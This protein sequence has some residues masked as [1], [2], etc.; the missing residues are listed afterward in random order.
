MGQRI[1]Q[2]NQTNQT[3]QME[4]RGVYALPWRLG[5]APPG[6]CSDVPMSRLRWWRQCSRAAGSVPP[7]AL[8][9]VF[10]SPRHLERAGEPKTPQEFSQ[11]E[12]LGFPKVDSWTL[13]NGEESVQVD[14][15][16][17]Y[18]RYSVGM[19]KR[20]ATLD[21]WLILV[22]RAVVADDLAAGRLR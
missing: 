8:M 22:P 11:H 20:L 16:G 14:V 1:R 19:V 12:C 2:M 7:C 13:Q 9:Q 4:P 21:Q 17:R 15:G 5:G 3:N 10:A 6:N 18:V